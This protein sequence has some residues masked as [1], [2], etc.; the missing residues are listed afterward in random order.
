MYITPPDKHQ[1]NQTAKR[2]NQ[3]FHDPTEMT[4]IR[5]SKFTETIQEIESFA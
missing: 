3:H 4:I 1:D 2:K 5:N